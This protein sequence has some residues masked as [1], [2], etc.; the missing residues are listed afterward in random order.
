[1]KKL[2]DFTFGQRAV[3]LRLRIKARPICAPRHFRG[4]DATLPAS[5]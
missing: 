1:M 2:N 5:L 3:N 4:A